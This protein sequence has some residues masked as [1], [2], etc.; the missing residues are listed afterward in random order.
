MVLCATE[1]RGS[2]GTGEVSLAAQPGEHLVDLHTQRGE[3]RSPK[4]QRSLVPAVPP[5]TLTLVGG[6]TPSEPVPGITSPAVLVART[7]VSHPN[8]SFTCRHSPSWNHTPSSLSAPGPVALCSSLPALPRPSPPL[9]PPRLAAH[10]R[11]QR[12]WKQRRHPRH[13]SIPPGAAASCGCSARPQPA[14]MALA[15]GRGR[16]GRLVPVGGRRE[17]RVGAR[18][19]PAEATSTQAGF[20]A[21]CMSAWQ[22]VFA[23]PAPGIQTHGTLALS[24]ARPPAGGLPCPRSPSCLPLLSSYRGSALSCL[25]VGDVPP[26]AA[27][28]QTRSVVC[29]VGRLRW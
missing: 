24:A 14:Q 20:A 22:Q 16:Q 15:A 1:Q 8:P 26:A 2:A 28:G 23:H 9:R 7:H 21:A 29:C 11:W 13:S 6:T 12:P 17:G 5:C 18:P 25:V 19:G 10:R 3:T 4:I 27:T